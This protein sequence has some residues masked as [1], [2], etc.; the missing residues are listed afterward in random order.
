MD[1]YTLRD[2][3]IETRKVR[4]GQTH[5]ADADGEDDSDSDGT[6]TADSD[7]DNAD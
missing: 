6:D 5:V 4:G 2:E 3:D 1:D 7:A